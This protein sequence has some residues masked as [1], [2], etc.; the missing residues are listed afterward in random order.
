MNKQG[1]INQLIGGFVIVLIGISLV[2]SISEKV[3]E[4][5]N[6]TASSISQTLLSFVPIVFILAIIL[7]GITIAIKALG[8]GGSDE[9]NPRP[10]KQT[11]FQYVQE[12]IAIEKE[13][14]RVNG[15]FWWL[16]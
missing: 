8:Y 3:Q 5:R 11:Y 10:K 1:M 14:R 9:I 2:P 4:A 7:T 15:T 6:T 13:M 16:K 12:R